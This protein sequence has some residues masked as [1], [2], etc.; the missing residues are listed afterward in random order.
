MSAFFHLCPKD[1]PN[2]EQK[3]PSAEISVS[4]I[5]RVNFSKNT[6]TIRMEMII[7]YSYTLYLDLRPIFYGFLYISLYV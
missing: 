4:D 5:L 1:W 3:M 7:K 6:I 2:P